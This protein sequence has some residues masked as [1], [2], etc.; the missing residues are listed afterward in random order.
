MSCIPHITYLPSNADLNLHSRVCPKSNASPA[1][2][3]LHCPAFVSGGAYG[4]WVKDFGRNLVLKTRE[5]HFVGIDDVDLSAPF[6]VYA[7]MIARLPYGLIFCGMNLT[8]TMLTSVTDFSVLSFH[9][10]RHP[11]LD[12]PW[13]GSLQTP[14][15]DRDVPTILVESICD[16]S[17]FLSVATLRHLA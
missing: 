16:A 5:R 1:L 3:R 11:P 9:G 13:P 15:G 12:A 6:G 2:H 10:A 4:P 8:T 17:D 14:S 7:S